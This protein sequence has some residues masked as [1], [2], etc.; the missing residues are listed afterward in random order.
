MSRKTWVFVA[1][2]V[3]LAGLFVRLG[4][5]QMARLHERRARNAE[6][7]ARL[8]LPPVPMAQKR[9]TAS[10]H[11]VTVAGAADYDHELILTG[12][13]RNGSPGVY[14]LTPVRSSLND[15]A[16]VIIR[17]WVYAPDAAS[18]DLGRWRES[19]GVYSGYTALLPAIAAPPSPAGPA[20][21]LRT[22]SAAG[23]RALLPYPVRSQYVVS[24]D[25]AADTTPARLA[26]PSLDDGPHLSYAIQWFSFALIAV[27]GAGIVAM[28]ARVSPDDGQE[29]LDATRQ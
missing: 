9:D 16:V 6:I 24:Q 18:A 23:V 28:R 5:W 8:A 2:A 10:Y 27:V 22:L 12:R 26:P 20:R 7:E 1:L 21:R 29:R 25:S 15:S 4:V 13:S 11:R 17:G 3:V 19:R 14:I